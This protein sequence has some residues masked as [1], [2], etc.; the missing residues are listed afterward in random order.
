MRVRRRG[1][2]PSYARRSR[3]LTLSTPNKGVNPD[4]MVAIGAA[5]QGAV[6][7]DICRR[8]CTFAGV[9]ITLIDE[10]ASQ[11]ETETFH[12]KGGL[13]EMVQFLNANKKP[14][15]PEVL[16]LD[17]E[18]DDIGRASNPENASP[19][20]VR[21]PIHGAVAGVIEVDGATTPSMR[22]AARSIRNVAPVDV[23][24]RRGIPNETRAH[25]L[26]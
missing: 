9:I 15:H 17:T 3:R 23:A 14:L 13:K 6:L 19:P 10:R 5:V 8:R 24:E 12:A 25:N 7:T 20:W 4:E 18:R 26:S 16:Y 21:Q 1:L 2:R 22:K 11:A